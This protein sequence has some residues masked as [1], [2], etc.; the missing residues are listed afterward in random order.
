MN[1]SQ[2]K[3]DYLCS[4]EQE[5]N[6]RGEEK[7]KTSFWPTDCLRPAVEIYWKWMGVPETNPIGAE[8]LNMFGIAKGCEA[9]VI[10]RMV[11]TGDAVDLSN[12]DEVKRL[13]LSLKNGQIRI[14]MEREFVPITGYMDGIMPDSSPI[15]VKSTASTQ[16]ERRLSQGYPPNENY[17][18]QL[19]CYMDFIRADRGVLVTISRANGSIWFTELRHLGDLVFMT[20]EQSGCAS[21]ME[22]DDDSD[23]AEATPEVTTEGKEI[24]FDLQKEYL[25]WRRIM[26]DNIIGM[27]Q[28]KRDYEYKPAIT[29]EFLAAYMTPDGKHPKLRKAIKGERVLSDHIWQPQYCNWKDLWIQQE[30]QEKGFTDVNKF[31]SYSHED[32][33]L[34]M[35]IGGFEWRTTKSG[36][37]AGQRKLF[38]KKG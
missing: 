24:T 33:Q 26:E 27:K 14:E 21:A 35:H 2:I 11:K 1:C 36:K 37:N 30:M 13:G 3:T 31:C 34:M 10:D 9:V 38:K 12:A 4:L 5:N 17:L 7:A 15:E 23:D 18:Y 29:P 8:T 6:K 25:R 16:L 28:P 22:D 19:A 32:I 20:G